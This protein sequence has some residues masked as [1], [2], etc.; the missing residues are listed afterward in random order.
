[1]LKVGLARVATL[2]LLLLC[3]AAAAQGIVAG[4]S[5]IPSIDTLPPYEWD[6]KTPH[7]SLSTILALGALVPG[8]AQFY[9]GHNVRGGFL[10]GLELGLAYEV[11]YNKPMQQQKRLDDASP[12]RDSAGYYTRL[13]MQGT[14]LDSVPYW[15]KRRLYHMDKVRFYNDKKL[16]E[17]DLRRSELAWLL[18]LHVYGLFDAYGIWHNNQGHSVETRSVS[19]AAWRAALVPGLG[20]IYNEEYGKAG[21]LYMAII[22]S[23][24]SFDSR[25][26]MVDYYVK[27]HRTAVQEG[28]TTEA[29]S[30][31]EE[32][33]F[34]RK[35]RN[36]YI[37]GL[38]LFYLYSIADAAV[39][40]SLSDFDSP[41]YWAL[42]PDLST[43]G[44][45][46]EIG[47]RF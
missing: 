46:A 21:L 29:S 33:T 28:N 47:L 36:Q 9:T 13:L 1:M 25:Q 43:R 38:G 35:K 3:G 4:K 45:R 19:G 26:R 42:S 17:E 2:C 8:G 31:A 40:A 11:F 20:Q 30:T 23:V 16:A 22:G 10:L 12:Y 15:Q 24:A 27:R 41:V 37:W 5:G 44:A 34:F 32:L 14:R 6:V 18:G 39:D 7:Q